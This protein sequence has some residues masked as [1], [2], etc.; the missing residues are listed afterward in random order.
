MNKGTGAG[1]KNTN[2][3]GKKFEDKTNNENKLIDDGFIKESY[4]KTKYGYYLYKTIYFTL[5]NGLKLFI[6][7]KYDIDIFRCP[8]EAYIIKILEK[9]EQ[10]VEGSVETKLWSSPSLKREYELILGENFKIEYSLCLSKFLSNKFKSIDMKYNILKKILYGED[11]DYFL[12]IND[13]IN[14]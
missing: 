5:Q 11:D 2:I 3:Y 13:W 14:N 10:N 9:K 8:D 12:K 1:G 6:K 7:S 4:S